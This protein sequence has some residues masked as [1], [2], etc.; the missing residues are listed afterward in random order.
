MLSERQATILKLRNAGS[1]YK[2]IAQLHGLSATRIRAILHKAKTITNQANETVKWTHG[3]NKKT[4]NLVISAGCIDKNS[5]I[6]ALASGKFTKVS[7]VGPKTIEAITKWANHSQP[8]PSI[9]QH[10]FQ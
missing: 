2:E 10:D 3:L 8:N 7:G 4:E 5:V 9:N 1:T 6:E